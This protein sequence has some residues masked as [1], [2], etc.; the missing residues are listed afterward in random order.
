MSEIDYQELLFEHS[1]YLLLVHHYQKDY[2]DGQQK[3]LTK[4]EIVSILRP[5][6]NVDA[7]IEKEVEKDNGL[8]DLLGDSFDCDVAQKQ[9][10]IS[11]TNLFE[12]ALEFFE[13]IQHPFIK[14]GKLY[15]LNAKFSSLPNQ[16]NVPALTNC[17]PDLLESVAP[18][19]VTNDIVDDK[20]PAPSPEPS[21]EPPYAEPPLIDSIAHRRIP[22]LFEMLEINIGDDATAGRTNENEPESLRTVDDIGWNYFDANINGYHGLMLDWYSLANT[23]GQHTPSSDGGVID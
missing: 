10:R 14:R 4:Q 17:L 3:G 20:T 16:T 19:A 21:P 11:D 2:E 12:D 15:Y 8:I 9:V 13:S 22:D 7:G 6:E 1:S 5:N 23:I 18:T